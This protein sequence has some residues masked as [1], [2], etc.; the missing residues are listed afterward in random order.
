MKVAA[1]DAAV[2]G[3]SALPDQ[4]Q[5]LVL[6]DALPDAIYFKD[7]SSRFLRVSRALAAR[8]GLKDPAEAVGRSDADFFTADYAARTSRDEQ[9]IM[10]SGRPMVDVVEQGLWPDGRLTRGG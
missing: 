6:M 1:A 9:E 10:R 5:M 8:L 3:E 4:A 2:L 7:A